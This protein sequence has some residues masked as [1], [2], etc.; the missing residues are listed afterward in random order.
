VGG[1]ECAASGRAEPF[2]SHSFIVRRSWRTRWARS[3]ADSAII[4]PSRFLPSHRWCCGS[5]SARVV[6]PSRPSLR[7]ELSPEPS[8]G[9][10]CGS[11]SSDSDS[12]E[13]PLKS[14]AR[15]PGN[16]KWGTLKYLHVVDAATNARAAS[17]TIKV[18]ARK[19]T[20]TQ[21]QSQLGCKC[22]QLQIKFAHPSSPL[23]PNSLSFYSHHLPPILA[24][25]S[26]LPPTILRM[27][28][29]V[30]LHIHTMRF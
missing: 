11:S 6:S 30:L 19:T 14:A 24:T 13:E 1:Y 4:A 25:R 16:A 23:F 8:V 29:I 10:R 18:E 3:G 26:I 21:N 9:W 7:V 27:Q 17:K 12:D 28:L 20:A 5:V 15:V 22:A 2:C